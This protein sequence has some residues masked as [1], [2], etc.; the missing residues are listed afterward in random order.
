LI[1]LYLQ[2]QLTI[3]INTIFNSKFILTLKTLQED[4]LKSFELWLKSPWC[5]TNK[6]LIKLFEKLSKYY[7]DFDDR[8]LT[9]EKLFKQI[10]PNGKFSLRRMN[11]LLSEAY[12]AIEK[13]MIFQNLSNDQ[14]LQKDL[15]TKEFQQRH[16][17]DSFFKTINKEVQRLEDKPIKDWE[18]HLALLQFHRRVYHHPNPNPRMQ[19][20]SQTIVKMGKEIDLVY[21]LEK[22]MII[23]EK[24]FRN[25]ILKNENHEITEELEKWKIVSEGISHPS[26]E[27]YRL[28]FEYTEE[29]IFDHYL[30]L[31]K[32][33]LKRLDELNK[34]QRKIHF[35]YLLNDTTFLVRA[36]L[37]DITEFLPIYKFALKTDLLYNEG[38]L[39]FLTYVKILSASNAKKDF[40]F[41]NFFVKNYTIKLDKQY[42]D[43]AVNWAKAHIAN[44]RK[45]LDDC[46]DILLKH[47]F[48][49]LFFQ[50]ASKLLTTQTYFDLFLTKRSYQDYLFN[51]FDSFEKWIIREK[52]R[53]KFTKKSYLRFVQKSRSLAKLYAGVDFEEEKVQTL[54]EGEKNIQG[55]NWL[56]QKKNEILEI[57]KRGRST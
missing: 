4:E 30:K 38:V 15:L 24:I 34:T 46:L 51:F 12:L 32:I 50:L 20:G 55:L 27:F 35:T 53:S 39:S 47:D 57:K 26:I 52:F 29:N 16:L 1:F 25:R 45:K 18:D 36:G 22:A 40:I 44:R 8:R 14:V 28:R 49:V 37:F 17:E 9:K 48:K 41:S 56:K 19:A 31:R 6:N 10:L 13:F 5:N 3:K 11:N 43:D 42:Q 2:Y 54:L 21:L 33:L 7:P 23:N